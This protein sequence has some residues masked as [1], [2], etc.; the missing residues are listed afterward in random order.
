MVLR[1]SASSTA[2]TDPSAR[3][4]S[5]ALALAAALAL[6]A[7]AAPEPRTVSVAEL[8]QRP[9][10]RALLEG[11]RN[12][13]NGSFEQADGNF[14]AALAAGLADKRD[15]AIAYKHLAFIACAFN[16]LGECEANFRSAFS[17]NP[18]FRLTDAE[19]GHPVWGPV[20]R[21]VAAEQP[22]QPH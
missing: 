21:R 18:N 7:C 11:M 15:T 16:R 19:I 8:A 10:E 20:Y 17:A 13:D 14:R 22:V 6:G 3:R 9:G 4:R 1:R 2:S 5:L 12:Y